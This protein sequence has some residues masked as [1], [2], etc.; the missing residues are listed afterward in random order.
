MNEGTMELH[1]FS[2]NQPLP[3]DLFEESILSDRKKQDELM[4]KDVFEK[5]GVETSNK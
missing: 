2:F 3:D 4:S 5:D 1:W